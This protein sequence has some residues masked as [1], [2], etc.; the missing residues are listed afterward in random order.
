[1][2]R[3]AALDP[4]RSKCGLVLV[5]TDLGIVLQGKVLKS[6]SVLETLEEW[7][8]KAPFD[9]ILLGNGTA[10]AHW[11]EQLPADLLITVVDERGTTLKAR[12]RYWELWPPKGWRCLQ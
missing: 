2:T 11:R 3:I 12:T 1:M 6:D 7:R 9:R 8:S 10:S 4:G 5:D